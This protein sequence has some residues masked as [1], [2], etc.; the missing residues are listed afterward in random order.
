L[1]TD[2]FETEN[3]NVSL[4]LI[5]R[6]CVTLLHY[7]PILKH[8]ENIMLLI[9]CLA[10]FFSSVRFGFD[11]YINSSLN[12]TKPKHFFLFTFLLWWLFPL[13]YC[14]SI[15]N[16]IFVLVDT[17]VGRSVVHWTSIFSMWEKYDVACY[18]LN[19]EPQYKPHKG[20]RWV[21]GIIN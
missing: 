18:Y 4:G 21:L 2:V 11:F 15:K 3:L 14:F 10:T 6:R 9:F 5:T 16:Q 13:K 17:S 19:T 20:C 12:D 8:S 1:V 7:Y